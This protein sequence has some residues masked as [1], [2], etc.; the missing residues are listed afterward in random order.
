MANLTLGRNGGMALRSR[1]TQSYTSPTQARA[2]RSDEDSKHTMNIT[3]MYG[4]DSLTE[5]H[6]ICYT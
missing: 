2:V 5:E 1:V 6:E 3:S 4:T